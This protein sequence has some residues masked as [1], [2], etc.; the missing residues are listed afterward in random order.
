MIR[1][2]IPMWRLI[3]ISVPLL[4]M[5]VLWRWLTVSRWWRIPIEKFPEHAAKLPA[6][7]RQ[8]LRRTYIGALRR[9]SIALRRIILLLRHRVS[10]WCLILRLGIAWLLVTVSRRLLSHYNRGCCV[11]QAQYSETRR[12]SILFHV[13]KLS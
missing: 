1:L 6:K 9:L 7:G 5:A 8:K 12:D 3:Q 10:W 13:F 11:H 2:I 4:R